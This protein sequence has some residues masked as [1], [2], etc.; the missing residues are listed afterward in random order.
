MSKRPWW[1]LPPG[2]LHPLWWILPAIFIAWGDYLTGPIPQFPVLFAIPA[3]LAAWYS[4]KWA[5]IGVAGTIT[6]VRLVLWAAPGTP[7][8]L[9]VVFWTLVRGAIIVVIALWFDR[10]AQF[11][12]G[13]RERVKALE[14][15]L[16]ICTFCKSI[17]NEQGAWEPFEGYISRRSTAEF[18]HSL[19]PSC[20]K[21]HYADFMTS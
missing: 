7:H 1:L 11:E 16:P 5:A 18:S 2:R 10:L 13:L 19:C 15:L 6:A 3:M 4:G 8:A 21:A 14:G 12:R 9:S 20:G 17:K